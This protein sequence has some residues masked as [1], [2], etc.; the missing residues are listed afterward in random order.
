MAR[1]HSARQRD[2]DK[3]WDFA[4]SSD[5]EGW[6]HPDGYCAGWRSPEETDALAAEKGWPLLSKEGAEAIRLNR[7]KF[8][9]DG[10]AT[11]EEAEA[12]HREYVLDFE[13]TR[14]EEKDVHRKCDSCGTF[15][16]GRVALGQ[17]ERFN[18]CPSHQSREDVK[19]VGD[20]ARERRRAAQEG[21]R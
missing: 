7:D 2:Y 9:S 6:A 3:R 11:A 4:V 10:H 8:H 13:L 17:F 20:E 19:R 1:I 21:R 5:E 16:P 12:C 14:Y 15:T 18:L